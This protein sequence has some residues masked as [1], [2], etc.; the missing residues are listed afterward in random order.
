MSK[1]YLSVVIPAY[2]ESE[3]F[4]RGVLNEIHSFL[5]GQKFSWEVIL[6]NDGSSDRTEELLSAFV[7]RKKNFRLVSIPHGGKYAAVRKGVFEAKGKFTLFTDFD[8]STPIGEVK[9][10]LKFFERGGDIVISKRLR[11]K[12][13]DSLFSILRSKLFSYYRRLLILGNIEDTQVGFKA[14]KNSVARKLFR[15]LK[16]TNK[17]HKGAFMGAFDVELLFIASKKGYR[18][19]CVPVKWYRFESSRLTLKEPFLMFLDVLKIKIL[20]LLG[21]Y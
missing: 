9:K 12:R 15:N 10:F 16:V 14:F 6:I 19:D 3:N 11:A 8:Q 17:K 1:P 5:K 13:N 7:K 4:K 21:K 20:D 2:N 18:I